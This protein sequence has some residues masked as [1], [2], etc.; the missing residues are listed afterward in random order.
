MFCGASAAL[1]AISPLAARGLPMNSWPTATLSAAF[2]ALATG[3]E[4]ITK[5]WWFPPQESSMTLVSGALRR[6]LVLPAT[7]PSGPFQARSPSDRETWAT[8][9]VGLLTSVVP[10]SAWKTTP[11]FS[12]SHFCSAGRSQRPW[13]APS[14]TGEAPAAFP[15]SASQ[16]TISQLPQTAVKSRSPTVSAM[17]A[18]QPSWIAGWP[19]RMSLSRSSKVF[20][21]VALTKVAFSYPGGSAER[22]RSNFG[23]TCFAHHS[24]ARGP[25]A[26]AQDWPSKSA[27][28]SSGARFSKRPPVGN[29]TFD[30]AA[31]FLRSLTITCRTRGFSP[32][33]S[34][35][36]RLTASTATRR[37]SSFS[38]WA[39]AAAACCSASS[40]SRLNLGSAPCCFSFQRGVPE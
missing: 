30:R 35:R 14:E 24:A 19:R 4:V 18:P 9:P 12:M 13:A 25:G 2:T 28:S 34:T 8:A 5:N 11:P 20:V 37:R 23:N 1:P 7:P 15:G 36:P 40:S 10:P 17:A 3:A 32:T 33:L 29:G 26:S 39:A 6:S 16:S 21:N 22:L 38:S 31:T 27:K